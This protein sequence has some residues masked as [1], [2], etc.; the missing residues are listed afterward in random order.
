MLHVFIFIQPSNIAIKV[1]LSLFV[2]T[3]KNNHIFIKHNWQHF[4]YC[5]WDVHGIANL[6]TKL[7]AKIMQFAFSPHDGGSSLS[8]FLWQRTVNFVIYRKSIGNFC[9]LINY[10][11]RFSQPKKSHH[12]FSKK[13]SYS[14]TW[15]ISLQKI[16]FTSPFTIS[17]NTFHSNAFWKVSSISQDG[18]AIHN[19]FPLPFA[20][21]HWC[22]YS[23]Y[24]PENYWAMDIQLFR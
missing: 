5:V 17:P 12:R 13:K 20:Q 6:K 21:P 2:W 19:T 10:L 16:V 23:S 22:K 9:K 8:S 11:I 3:L 14:L 1:E 18:F 7:C 15:S 24:S 4:I